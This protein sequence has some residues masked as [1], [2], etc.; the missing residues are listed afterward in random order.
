MEQGSSGLQALVGPY[1]CQQEGS[2]ADP[3]AA[4]AAPSLLI[5]AK[6]QKKGLT[7]I[8]GH[9]DKLPTISASQCPRLYNGTIPSSG[10]TAVITKDSVRLAPSQGLACGRRGV[11]ICYPLLPGPVLS[12][13][14]LSTRGGSPVLLSA[15][16]LCHWYRPC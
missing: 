4:A 15:Y 11:A 13:A 7:L 16:L 5:W 10:D 12:L 1:C 14:Q 6:L 8:I 9:L 3:A 2:R